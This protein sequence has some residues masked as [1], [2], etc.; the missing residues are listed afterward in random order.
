MTEPAR[1][2]PADTE[3]PISIEYGAESIRVLKG[4]EANIRTESRAEAAS[5]PATFMSQR[6]FIGN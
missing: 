5:A 1:Q 2:T 4:L 6:R 3:H